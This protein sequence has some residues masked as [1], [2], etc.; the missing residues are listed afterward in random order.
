MAQRGAHGRRRSS[1]AGWYRETDHTRN[2]ARRLRSCQRGGRETLRVQTEVLSASACRTPGALR[3]T[4]MR[5]VCCQQPRT[6]NTHRGGALLRHSRLNPDS[7]F[8]LSDP[9]ARLPRLYSCSCALH[10]REPSELAGVS[11]WSGRG[12]ERGKHGAPER[13][14]DVG[15][16]NEWSGCCKVQRGAGRRRQG[17]ETTVRLNAGCHSHAVRR[18]GGVGPSGPCKRQLV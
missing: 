17:A 9:P 8:Q 6:G 2:R 1:L 16:S 18:G 4:R 5:G 15:G 7:S 3:N 13:R 14:Q 11:R 10:L 12:R